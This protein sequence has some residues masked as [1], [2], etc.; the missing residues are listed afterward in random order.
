LKIRRLVDGPILATLLRLAA[1][2]V[3][4]A[5]ASVALLTLDAYFVSFLGQASRW[6]F[7]S[8]F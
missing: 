2:N 1:P 8:S 5:A 3:A 4:D 7:R 6:C